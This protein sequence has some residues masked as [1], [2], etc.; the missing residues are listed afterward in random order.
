MESSEL[1]WSEPAL[2]ETNRRTII[3]GCSRNQAQV[4]KVLICAQCFAN[5]L[6]FLAPATSVSS[7]M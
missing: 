2:K 6:N 7:E 1:P 4:N 5:A 3:S